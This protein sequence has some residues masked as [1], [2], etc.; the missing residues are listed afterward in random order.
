MELTLPVD[1]KRMKSSRKREEVVVERLA[2]LEQ[3]L[4]VSSVAIEMAWRPPSL[5]A[6]RIERW[7]EPACWMRACLLAAP[8]L[9][10]WGGAAV[11]VMPAALR[12]APHIEAAAVR[13]RRTLA[14][15]CLP[16]L[17]SPCRFKLMV[18]N[19]TGV[20]REAYQGKAQQARVVGLRANMEY[21]FCVKAIYNDNSFLWSESRA[22]KTKA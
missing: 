14:A 8:Q 5:K 2:I 15:C 19:N 13:P 11:L 6:E 9:L 22:F 1:I 4:S 20:V 16:L 12:V 21:V 10:D 7:V 17:L 3:P 18:A